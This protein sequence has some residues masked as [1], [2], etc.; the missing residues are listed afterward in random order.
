MATSQNGWPAGER[1]DI[2]IVT[3][4]VPGTKTKLPV[5]G[6]DVA[7]V[8]LWVA[9]RW[10][11]EVEPLVEPGN[12]GYA[13]RAVRGATSGLSN[14]ASGTAIDLNAPAHPLATEPLATL[15]KAQVATAKRIEADT[16]G[17]VRWGGSYSGRKD[18][19]HWEINAGPA[20]VAA[21]A[22]R[23]NGSTSTPAPTP[24]GDDMYGTNERNELIGRIDE[25]RGELDVL[26]PEVVELKDGVGRLLD[27]A[28]A[29]RAMVANLFARPGADVD[30]NA[31]ANAL[32]PL[33]AP[34]LSAKTG[35]SK[36]DVEAVIRSVLGGLNEPAA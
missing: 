22:A 8:L 2:G 29:T 16:G 14:H 10:H 26:L 11:N 21:L 23:I 6:G 13:Y 19:M 3:V 28:G 12:W 20:A 27:A 5:K 15:T 7:D 33:L 32:V 30:E 36:A 9:T 31:L 18:T 17:V 4:T 34:A 1:A 35:A 25:M 24:E